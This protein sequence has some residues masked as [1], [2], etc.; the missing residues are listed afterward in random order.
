M[1]YRRIVPMAGLLALSSLVFAQDSRQWDG[2][3]ELG[4]LVTTGNTEETNLKGGLDLVREWETWRTRYE[5]AALYSES[6]DTTTAERYRASA[7]AD[8][9]LEQN[10]FLFVRGS[11]DD[12]RFSGYDYQSSATAGYGNR[13]W[14]RGEESFLD[15]SAGLGYRYNKLREA[16]AEGD[17][18]EDGAVARLAGQ[19]DYE[20]TPTSLFRQELG[21]E[22]GLEESNTLTTSVTSIQANFLADL[23]LKAAYR[24]E[25]NSDA[26]AGSES[27]DTETSF[28]LLYTF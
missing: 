18:V 27:V 9:K 25:H 24:L 8:Y 7:Q 20:L 14:Q 3:V 17:E 2:E 11:Y 6:E 19:F 22:I 13:V 1:R 15:L 21:T 23:A 26:P 12:D 4:L 16:N 28:T 5:A 10:Q